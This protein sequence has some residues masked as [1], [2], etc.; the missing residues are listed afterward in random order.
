MKPALG[1]LIGPDDGNVAVVSWAYWN[2]RFKRD[3]SIVGKHIVIDSVP[4]TI[5]GVI[6]RDFAG[7]ELGSK[8]DVW[9]PLAMEPLLHHRSNMTTVGYW[10]KLA[11]RLKP[12]VS[13]EQARAEMPALFRW[14]QD[15]EFRHNDDRS[16]YEIGRAHV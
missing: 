8:W 1:R 6:S 2:S 11:A 4:A 3:P 9:L 15:K 10:L 16:V 5:V 13:I 12:G 14:T 7:M